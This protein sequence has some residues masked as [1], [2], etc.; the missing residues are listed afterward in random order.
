MLVID[1]EWEDGDDS[2]REAEALLSVR[3][4]LV[5]AL[6]ETK[7]ALGYIHA[8]YEGGGFYSTEDT[9]FQ[10]YL[11]GQVCAYEHAIAVLEGGE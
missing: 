3:D 11:E 8:K 6:D 7:N 5:V 1:R 9:S 10:N 2:A 4:R